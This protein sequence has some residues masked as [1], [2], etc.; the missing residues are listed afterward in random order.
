MYQ[1]LTR[2]G[3]VKR[4]REVTAHGD[5]VSLW[6]EENVLGLILI[7]IAQLHEC[8]TKQELDALNVGAE[9]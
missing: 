3:G 4:K 2:T 6:G 9:W 7:T 8:T 5:R 1:W